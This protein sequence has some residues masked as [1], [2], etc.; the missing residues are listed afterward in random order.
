MFDEANIRN[1]FD[2]ENFIF[3]MAGHF[4]HKHF[5]A[6]RFYQISKGN[7]HQQKTPPLQEGDGAFMVTITP[8]TIYEKIM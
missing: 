7:G 4:P 1:L 2:S 3:C 8:T 5:D 6:P